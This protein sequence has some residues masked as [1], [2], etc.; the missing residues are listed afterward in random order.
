MIFL[1][2]LIPVDGYMT[3]TNMQKRAPL[4][5]TRL[6]YMVRSIAHEQRHPLVAG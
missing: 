3:T 2:H 4:S 5:T 6:E 1:R